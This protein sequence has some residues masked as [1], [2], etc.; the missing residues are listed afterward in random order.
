M[1]RIFRATVRI[2]MYIIINFLYFIIIYSVII[3]TIDVRLTSYL[4]T[5]SPHHHL[6]PPRAVL[7]HHRLTSRTVL[8]H[9]RLTSPRT[10]LPHHVPSYLTYRLTSRTVL[11]TQCCD[12]LWRRGMHVLLHVLH[13]N[14]CTVWH[15]DTTCCYMG[16]V[17]TC[18][19]D[20]THNT[21]G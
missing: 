10:V 5:V 9:H 18:V 8:P 14:L 19:H 11:H 3:M 13:D 21:H 15:H 6:V 2:R 16:C 17:M 1:F 4:T 20:A 12:M 7:P